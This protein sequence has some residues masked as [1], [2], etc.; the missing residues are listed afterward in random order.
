MIIRKKNIPNKKSSTSSSQN[1]SSKSSGKRNVIKKEDVAILDVEKARNT[2]ET[3]EEAIQGAKDMI[4]ERIS[5][6][7]DT[8]KALRQSGGQFY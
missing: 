7:S 5:D 6:N 1:V 4:A 2:N 8:R 3:I